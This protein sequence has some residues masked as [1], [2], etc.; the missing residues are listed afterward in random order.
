M[1]A[2]EGT[3]LALNA[4]SSSLKFAL[5]RRGDPPQRRL[6]GNVDRIGRSDT[7]LAFRDD[8][9]NE[10]SSIV[11][12]DVD[13]A[14]AA[15][16]LLDWLDERVGLRSIAAAGHRIAHGGP[17]Y[18]E[19]H[20]VTPE[21]VAELR[22]VS[23][24]APAHV[25]AA[26]AVIDALGA[27][28][29]HLPQFACFDTSFHRTMP[30]VARSF[31]LPRSLQRKGVERYGFHGLS[32]AFLMDELARVA[33][34]TAA[35]GRVILAHLGNGAS[36][37][38]V[39]EGRSVDTSMGFTPAS[40]IPMSSRSGDLDPGLVGYLAHAE[41][42]SAA[43]FDDM[44]NHRSGLL[45]LSETSSD[46]RDLLAAEARDPRAA[47]AVALFCYHVK[48]WI[49]AFAAVLGGVD[50]LVFAGGI[51]EN[52]PVIRERICA[53]LEFLGIAL[54][55]RRNDRNEPVISPDAAR[56]A[57]RVMRT[58][59]ALTIAT[60]VSRMLDATSAPVLGLPDSP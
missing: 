58:D 46:M 60:T 14:L 16:F 12:G 13:H 39:R 4:G 15:R 23:V 2:D 55:A 51:G 8:V 7:K 48:K 54:D 28:A 38:A 5:Y 27:R 34:A 44:V 37:A 30:Q 31:A 3:L 49:G 35:R 40:G 36:L 11:V 22:R 33:G 41:G 45:G 32:Y 43:Q 19:P 10:D 9:R 57:V 18:L 21:L 42:M 24:L 47:E 52:Q 59:E 29:A 17:R 50:T 56:V 6:S 25:P 53:G 1:S 26:L 20:R